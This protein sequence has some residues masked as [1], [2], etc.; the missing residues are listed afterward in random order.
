MTT[1]QIHLPPKLIPVFSPP[2]GD[3]RYRGA[4]GG[5]GSGKSFSFALMAAVFGYAEPLRIL[6]TRELQVSIKESMY[7]E[8]KNAIAS[9]PWLET[10]YEI[11]ENYIR[12]ANGTEFIFRGLR[13]NISSIKSMAQIDLCIVEEAEQVPEH[14][15][16]ALIPTVRAPK[17]EIW[18]IWNPQR[19]GSPVDQ[20]FVKSQPESAIIKRLNYEDNPWFP[21]VLRSEME[22]DYERDPDKY[23]H[24]WLG[25]YQQRS[26][27]RVFRNWRVEAFDTPEDVDRF[28]YG[29]DWG[30]ANDPTVL[31]R[32]FLQGR[33]LY[34]D[35]EAYAIGC[36][37]D[38]TPQLFDRVPG[39]RDWPITADSARPETISYMQRQGFRMKSAKKGAGSIEDGIEF[40][41]SFDIVVHP[42]CTHTVD[43]LTLY[44]YQVDQY[45]DEVLPKLED[46]HNHVIDALRYSVEGMRRG[47]TVKSK[48]I[49]GLV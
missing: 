39:S 18:V 8:I 37:I 23:A 32:C 41:K 19:D 11:G 31:V 14:S 4:Y 27:A 45:T 26:E 1:A 30:F 36:E 48:P 25:H 7:A 46:K 22:W 35:K 33:T 17:S 10:H 38:H 24:I 34:V 49:R 42:S 40:L 9:Q 16:L 3:V 15:W 12:G 6:C 2:R 5:R 13:H 21:D 43:E 29:A 47:G 20:R 44:S 28:Y